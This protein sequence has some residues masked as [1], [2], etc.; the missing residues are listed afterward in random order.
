MRA[1][2]PDGLWDN[3][4]QLNLAA[5]VL[6]A[7]ALLLIA[8][9]AVQLLVRSS[10]FPLRVIRV[11]GELLHV[12]RADI[13]RALDGR[14]HGTFFDAR[15]DDLRDAFEGIA[16]VR[17]AHVRRVWPDRIEARLEE[18]VPF[19]RWGEEKQLV[20][21]Q[22]DV[23][24]GSSDAPLPLLAGPPGTSREVTRR[25]AQV[26][27]LLSPLA[28]EPVA[29]QLSARQAWQVK[30]SNGLTLQLGRDTDKDP[31][32]DRLARF[33]EIYPQ[34][35]GP[36]VVGARARRFDQVD[37]RYANGFALRVPEFAA[38]AGDASRPAPSQVT[39]KPRRK[40]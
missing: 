7:C 5:N 30:L 19:A 35:I 18:H 23:F 37:L 40:A 34:T 26:R 22:G 29:V 31:L 11:E 1:D 3:P 36:I 38:G 27:E 33:V 28:L 16:W 10:A 4:R 21:V 24:E 14:V 6:F 12:K 17:R 9:A 32:A 13:A 39:T 25:Y 20:N 8:Y 15:L 2:A